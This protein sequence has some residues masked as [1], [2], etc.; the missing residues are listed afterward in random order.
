[1]SQLGQGRVDLKVEGSAGE[2]DDWGC[3]GGEGAQVGVEVNEGGVCWEWWPLVWGGEG[4][5]E[6]DQGG[7]CGGDSRE[8]LGLFSGA[9][10][11]H[12]KH[13]HTCLADQAV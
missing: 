8:T 4:E 10:R 11:A 5:Q 13:E 12:V 3:G 2:G 9:E 6:R 7:A 1:M